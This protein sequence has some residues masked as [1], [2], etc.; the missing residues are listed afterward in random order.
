MA[1]HGWSVLCSRVLVDQ[2]TNQVSLIDAI[3]LFL[4]RDPSVEKHFD[5]GKVVIVDSK[6]AIASWWYRT[7]P[8]KAEVVQA[9]LRWVDPKGDTLIEAPFQV[10]LASAAGYRAFLK[11]PQLKLT[12]FGRYWFVTEIREK[13]GRR[14]EWRAVSTLPLDVKPHPPASPGDEPGP[15]SRPSQAAASSPD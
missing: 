15:A 9:R 6:V 14:K 1:E 12:G 5:D 11:G 7:D 4:V 13:R 8:G 10:D 3:D 2:E